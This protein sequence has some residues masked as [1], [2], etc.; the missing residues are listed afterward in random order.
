[1]LFLLPLVSA[2]IYPFASL[3]LKRSLNEGCGILRSAFI[4]NMALF[5]VFLC[6]LPFND[7]SPE[8]EHINWALIAG[9]CFFGGQVFTFLAIR[10]GDVSVQAPLMGVKVIFV[11]LFSYTIRP[12][13]VPPLIWTGSILA[14]AAIF[15]LG[16]ANFKSFKKNGR[17]VFWS[18]VAC[19]CFGGS[20]T[21]AG[22]KSQEFGPIPFIVVMVSVVACCSLFFIPFFSGSLRNC[23]KVA[24]KFATLG[25]IAIGLQ[26]MILNLSLAVFGQA[27]PM[28]IIYS[29]R[30]LWGVL[31]V[32]F[33]GK[34][35]GNNEAE[36][37]G[38]R[39]MAKRFA[40]ALLLSSA[41][42]MVFI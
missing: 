14:A 40:G 28:N 15:L 26:G 32:W 18:L 9:M 4:S 31:I 30:A 10:S 2:I 3:F 38:N 34:A 27:T 6:A 33:L 25:G 23:P 29:T 39:I 7:R 13:E 5:S 20:D 37:Q 11:A 1:M 21:L 19:A 41:V 16:G 22:Y 8:W 36:L 17:T 12:E 42:I 35:L 24:I